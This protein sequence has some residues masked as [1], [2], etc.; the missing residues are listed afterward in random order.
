MGSWDWLIGRGPGKSQY[1]IGAGAAPTE[2]L[3]QLMRRAQGYADSPA[4]MMMQRG[5]GQ[6]I[7]AG[8]SAAASARG[9]SP[10]LAARMSGEREA[11]AMSDVGYQS[12]MLR[13]QEQ[14]AAQQMLANW[15]AEQERMKLQQDMYNAARQQRQGMLGSVL[16]TAGAIGGAML[17]GPWGAQAGAQAGQQI[18][19]SFAGAPQWSDYGFG[20]SGMQGVW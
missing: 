5:L 16:G 9:M 6:Q 15:L 17:G 18:G 8:R 4:Q 1:E 13:A 7:S 19:G 2:L 14:T 11:R 10:G 12:S 20:E 3:G